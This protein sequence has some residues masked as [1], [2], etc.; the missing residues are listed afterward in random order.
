MS[1]V[2]ATSK[3]QS[4]QQPTQ[5]ATQQAQPPLA[6]L[7]DRNLVDC[8][9]STNLCPTAFSHLFSASFSC[10]L[11]T[12]DLWPKKRGPPLRIQSLRHRSCFTLRHPGPDS[13]SYQSLSLHHARHCNLVS[14]SLSQLWPMRIPCLPLS[15]RS[16]SKCQ[17]TCLWQACGHASGCVIW[18][19]PN[20]QIFARTGALKIVEQMNYQWSGTMPKPS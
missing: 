4:A 5:Q 12:T 17:Y 18:K 19:I 13:Q 20:R 11:P 3:Q 14:P 9:R 6:P 2:L 10:L 1:Q 16:G 7:G 8:L 15:N